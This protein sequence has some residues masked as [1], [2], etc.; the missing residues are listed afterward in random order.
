[1]FRRKYPTSA[2]EWWEEDEEMLLDHHL[3]VLRTR[4]MREADFRT[5]VL[6]EVIIMSKQR[7]V[8]AKLLIC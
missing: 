1:M 6:A 7:V 4:I 8:D 2:R 5:G 3:G